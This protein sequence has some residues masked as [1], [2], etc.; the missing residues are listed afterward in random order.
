MGMGSGLQTPVPPAQQAPVTPPLRE[1]DELAALKQ[2]AQ[3]MAQ[4][5]QEITKRIEEL[6]QKK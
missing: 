6:E 3:A 2:Q 1:Q 4:G 5:L